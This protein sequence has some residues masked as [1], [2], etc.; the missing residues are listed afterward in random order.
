MTKER[1]LAELETMMAI[2]SIHR[3]GQDGNERMCLRESA[4]SYIKGLQDGA[5]IALRF[6]KG[7][8]AQA[9]A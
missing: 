5:R 3:G 9:G 1:E 7:A 8:Q 6:S 2:E 4:L